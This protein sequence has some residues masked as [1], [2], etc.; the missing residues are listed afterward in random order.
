MQVINSHT[1]W[2][3]LQEVW[4]GDVYPVSWYEH[5][6]SEVR[7]CFQLITQ[8]TQEDLKLIENKLK[9]FGV[10]VR[11]PRYDRIEDYV[12]G[13]QEFLIKPQIMPRDYYTVIGNTLYAQT[14]TTSPWQS[15]IDEYRGH[16]EIVKDRLISGPL[17]ISGSNVVR[18]GRDIYIDLKWTAE[19]VGSD[20]I[21]I[22]RYHNHFAQEFSDYRVHLIFNGG[23]ID[24]CFALLKPGLILASNYF[25]SYDVTFPNWQRINTSLPEFYEHTPNLT[26][27]PNFLTWWVPGMPVNRAF[28]QHVID[29][30]M[31]WVGNY[32]ET[33]FEVNCLV[34]D[35]KNVLVLG[36]HPAIFRELEQHGITP[37]SLP[38]RTR[39]FW[40]GGL[41][42]LT[43]DI[44]RDDICQDYFPQRGGP[45]INIVK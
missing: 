34:I 15:I 6:E 5:L 11:R 44:R 13:P 1:N 30:A 39:T 25:E 40:D 33:Y 7:D 31:T 32:T 17:H 41:H 45:N 21:L 8:R 16:G 9:E 12:R 14:M 4:L 22:N 28:N 43:L 24:G 38:F 3:R 20:E 36:E 37:H 26:N 27:V 2:G 10:A 42:C 35:E 18:A 29:H 19:S 23:H